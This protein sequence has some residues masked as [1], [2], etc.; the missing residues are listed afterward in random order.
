LP[1]EPRRVRLHF[2]VEDTGPGIA[3]SDLERIFDPF[4]RSTDGQDTGGL[5][6]GLAIGRQIVR[7]MGGELRVASRP[8]EGSR[9]W[10]EI[11]LDLAAEEDIPLPFPDLDIVG[12]A[13]PPRAILVVEDHVANRRVLEQLLI[14]LGFLVYAAGGVGEGLS[15]LAAAPC[16]L[17]LLD[18]RLPDGSAWEVL[19][20]LRG[21]WQTATAPAM[22]LSAQPPHP[23]DDW[24]DV[25]GFDAVL[26][27]PVGGAEVLECIGRLLGLAWQ[28]ADSAAAPAGSNRAGDMARPEPL[29]GAAELSELGELI[30]QSAVYEIE[31]WVAHARNTMPECG[32]FCREVEHCLAA[33]DFARMAA[34]VAAQ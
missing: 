31:E 9:F 5:G 1:A 8:G 27:K 18:Q 26:L 22:L 21:G 3:A 25:P 19:R 16:D 11:S 6:L 7:A 20:A 34:L 10:F 33:L 24:G 29:P 2:A 12:Y 32:A 15:V 23:P 14:E 17:A 4:E 28:R 13:G 30:R